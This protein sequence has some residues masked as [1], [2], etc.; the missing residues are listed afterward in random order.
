MVQ[1][2]NYILHSNK[3]AAW[4]GHYR[5][6]PEI[7]GYFPYAVVLKFMNFWVARKYRNNGTFYGGTKIDTVI[8]RH[9]HN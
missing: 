5:L 2:Y 4:R 7:I 1:R 3:E 6:S 9:F 8:T